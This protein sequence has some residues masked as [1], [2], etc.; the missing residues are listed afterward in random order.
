MTLPVT[1]PEIHHCTSQ[2]SESESDERLFRKRSTWN[3]CC[4]KIKGTHM[5]EKTSEEIEILRSVRLSELPKQDKAA[6]W[7][8]LV[9]YMSAISEWSNPSIFRLPFYLQIFWPG[10]KAEREKTLE[11]QKIALVKSLSE[12]EIDPATFDVLLAN[13]TDRR[14]KVRFGVTFLVLTVL[15]TAASYAVI[16]CDAIYKWN[17]SQVAISAIIIETPMQFIG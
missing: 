13:E 11:E 1:L 17:I 10:R 16:A 5:Q 3:D 12:A 14:L 15:F 8:L 9:K 4:W 7:N 6:Y 2:S